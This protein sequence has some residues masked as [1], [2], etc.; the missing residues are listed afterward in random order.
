MTLDAPISATVLLAEI[1]EELLRKV[2]VDHPD[3]KTVSLVTISVSH[4]QQ[5]WNMQLELSLGPE[6]EGH[7]PGS[8]RN[9]ARGMATELLTDP[10]PFW[11]GGDRIRIGSFRSFSFRTRR[12]SRTGRKEPLTLE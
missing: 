12:V 9:V 1:A 11:K 6:D 2:M 4:L 8:K 3:E 5:R 7:L 10:R